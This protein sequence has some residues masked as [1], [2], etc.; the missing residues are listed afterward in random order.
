MKK[1]LLILF[2]TSLVLGICI[3]FGL[4]SLVPDLQSPYYSKKVLT[5]VNYNDTLYLKRKDLGNVSTLV[6]STS[7]EPAFDPDISLEYIYDVSSTPFLYKQT[8]DSLIIYTRR[9]SKVPSRFE[10]KVKILQVLL[11]NPQIM[12]LIEDRH[13]KQKGI[14]K[15]N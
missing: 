11:S 4:F 1:L 13:L 12:K 15:V 3:L 2:F 10:S 14:Q 6:I 5:F 7:P 9:L 8:T